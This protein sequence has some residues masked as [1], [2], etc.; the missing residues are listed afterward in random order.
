MTST[1]GQ[2]QLSE[3]IFTLSWEDPEVDKA[4]LRIQPTDR[5]VTVT[6]GGCNTLTLLLEDP[7]EVFAVDIDPAQSHVL[8]LKIAAMRRLQYA[9]FL[10]FLGL[11]K[12]SRRIEMYHR[13]LD[14]LPSEARAFWDANRPLIEAGFLGTGRYERFI[15][16]FRALLRI[17]QG[18]K[19]IERLFEN[20]TLESQRSYFED[21]WNTRRWRGLFDVFFSKR[22]LGR[23]GLSAD[24]FQFEDGSA[25]FAESFFRRTRHALTE[26]PVRG[27][28]FLSQYLLGRYLEERHMPEYLLEPNYDVIARR[29]D[30]VHVITRDMKYW[31]ADQPPSS[32]DCFALSNICELMDNHDTLKTFQEVART[33]RPDARMSFRNLMV[34]RKVPDELKDRI[35][36]DDALSREL[37][38]NDRSFVYS[39]VEA[40]RLKT[41]ERTGPGGH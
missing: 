13:L 2:V 35:V 36:R 31:L 25:S 23:R 27:N 20:N 39:R 16:L 6:S 3:L 32:F 11:R 4:A 30:R 14:D 37:I 1:E 5:L 12:S 41:P 15:A 9:E 28:Y 33:A 22:V 26:L 7:R 19:R 8:E 29:I 10:E 24:Y 18:K 40:L 21:V 38:A 17:L 34:N